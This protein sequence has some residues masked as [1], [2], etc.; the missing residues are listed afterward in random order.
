MVN[1]AATLLMALTGCDSFMFF[2]CPV[3][4]HEEGICYDKTP[5]ANFIPI[6]GELLFKK[7]YRCIRCHTDYTLFMVMDHVETGDGM[8][9]KVKIR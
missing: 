8:C 5:G 3:C 7:G 1:A 6:N 9:Y 2:P 4:N